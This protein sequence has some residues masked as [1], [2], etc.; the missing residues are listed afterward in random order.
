MNRPAA[1]RTT[2]G[3]HLVEHGPEREDI[4]PRICRFALRLFGRHVGGSAEDRAFLGLK[5]L[6]HTRGPGSDALVHRRVVDGIGQ[7]REA[8]IENFD[9][10]LVAGR[11][12]HDVGRLEVAME[13][14][15]RVRGG[16]RVG[17]LHTVL[18]RVADTQPAVANHGG[19]RR[20]GDV[21][22][23]HEVDALGLTDVVDSN[24][25]RVIQRGRGSRLLD[26]SFPALW[27]DRA[28]RAEELDGDGPAEPRIE[29]TVDDAHA[30]FTN[31]RQ[32]L[33]V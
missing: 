24:D 18:Q 10:P 14:A 1:E 9:R 23:R 27:V 15:C 8:E 6:S 26:E 7:L 11:A 12:Q 19:E 25:V 29:R 3:D 17:Y 20:T 21:L 2:A 31:R 22:H 4:G 16:Q 30:A 5:V 32:D 33:V 13:N 28:I